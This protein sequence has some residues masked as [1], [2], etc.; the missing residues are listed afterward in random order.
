MKEIFLKDGFGMLDL[1][2]DTGTPPS[3]LPSNQAAL[4]IN[5]TFRDLGYV[6]PRPG[7]V[8]HTLVFSDL[9]STIPQPPP[10]GG[11]TNTPGQGG[12]GN[13]PVDI[14]S[15]GTGG[16]PGQPP[17]DVPPDTGGDDGG[18]GGGDVPT[19]KPS[20]DFPPL[21]QFPPPE[22]INPSWTL[23][24][25]EAGAAY[26]L[27]SKTT[28]PTP[29]DL[30][31]EYRQ[32]AMGVLAAEINTTITNQISLGWSYVGFMEPL[33]SYSPYLTPGLH[34]SLGAEA[35]GATP[36]FMVYGNYGWFLTCQVQFQKLI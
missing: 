21:T 30:P 16:P 20:D 11:G 28:Y 36:P 3:L 22:V 35:L 8:R 24:S 9:S 34:R 14:G 6:K 2:C 13:P 31:L 32:Y 12:A 29:S 23:K 10:S 5:A 17:P 1:G 27:D 7:F 15:G 33:W 18:G 4:A 25:E 26:I 19:W